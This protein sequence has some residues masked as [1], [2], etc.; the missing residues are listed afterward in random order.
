MGV[1]ERASELAVLKAIGFGR[2]VI[3]GT[4]LA[5]AVALS[6]VAGCAGVG[7]EP[8]PVPEHATPLQ[9]ARGRRKRLAAR[10]LDAH[11]VRPDGERRG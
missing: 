10:Y 1:R 9:L 3:F 11:G 4:L 5:E 7:R 2:R 8:P 6:T